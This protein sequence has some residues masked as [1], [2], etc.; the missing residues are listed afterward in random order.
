MFGCTVAIPPPLRVV[1]LLAH[2]KLLRI[3]GIPILFPPGPT[4]VAVTV[5]VAPEA[6]AVTPTKVG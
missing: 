3:S 4:V 1:A 5:T 2:V 6:V